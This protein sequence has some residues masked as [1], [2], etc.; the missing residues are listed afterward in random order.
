M[1]ELKDEILSI[2]NNKAEGK[3]YNFPN[4]LLWHEQ[5]HY[6]IDVNI[7]VNKDT[8]RVW[9]KG[10]LDSLYNNNGNGNRVV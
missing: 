9:I 7:D 3:L 5:N 2:L 1:K 8:F 10:I 6:L 4:L